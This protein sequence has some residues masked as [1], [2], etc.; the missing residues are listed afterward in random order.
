MNM[1]ISNFDTRC[2]LPSLL[3]EAVNIFVYLVIEISSSS[4]DQVLYV[5]EVRPVTVST[6]VPVPRIESIEE[7]N[8]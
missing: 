2:A 8:L 1:E 7:L 4:Y 6:R 5:V 3:T